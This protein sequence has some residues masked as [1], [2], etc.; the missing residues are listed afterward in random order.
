M[1]RFYRILAWVIAS[2]F[3]VGII[4]PSGNYVYDHFYNNTTASYS[5]AFLLANWV[6]LTPVSVALAGLA[7]W[8]WWQAKRARPQTGHSDGAG[9]FGIHQLR[10]SPSD[11]TGRSAEIAALMAEIKRHRGFGVILV[12][13]A[14]VGKT[15][16]ALE[17][18]HHLVLQYPDGQFYVDLKGSTSAP[19]SPSAAMAHVIHAYYAAAQLPSSEEAIEGFYRSVLDSKRC[20]LLFD[21]AADTKQLEPLLVPR[22]CIML[23]TSRKQM[24]L[25]GLLSKTID[26]LPRE[27]ATRLILTIAPR[28]GGQADAFASTCGGLPLALRLVSSALAQRPD[29]DPSEYLRRLNDKQHRLELSGTEAAIRQSYDLLQPQLRKRWCQLAAFQGGF[30]RLAASAIWSLD[31]DQTQDTLSALVEYSMLLWDEASHR[32]RLHDLL[33]LYADGSL[34][35]AG[36]AEAQGLHAQYYPKYWLPPRR[37]TSEKATI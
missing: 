28:I 9:R 36:R 10:P 24:A 16:L 25:A 34:D 22:S 33:G 2:L 19:L 31:Q 27:D 37:C 8:S 23:V 18:A 7:I 14:G 29:L 35:D 21:N 12:G 13:M 17:L 4:G 15:T 30:D 26:V 6:W 32:Y 3:A 5:V 11:F 1:W 20:L